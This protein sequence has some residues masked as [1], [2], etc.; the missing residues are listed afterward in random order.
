MAEGQRGRSRLHK[1]W[2]LVGERVNARVHVR[3]KAVCG[4]QL[5]GRSYTW[6]TIVVQVVENGR[7]Y[8][9]DTNG[10]KVPI[11]ISQVTEEIEEGAFW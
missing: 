3:P 11:D 1:I 2:S 6:V 8:S 5:L 10:R 4:N 7:R 9:R